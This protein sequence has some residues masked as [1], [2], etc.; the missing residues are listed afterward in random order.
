LIS[1]KVKIQASGK[2]KRKKN[3]PWYFNQKDQKKWIKLTAMKSS[4]KWTRNGGDN[5]PKLL[6]SGG[7][8]SKQRVRGV[9]KRTKLAV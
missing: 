6:V 1:K 4:Q 3:N 9:S 7:N 2:L 5:L 8:K